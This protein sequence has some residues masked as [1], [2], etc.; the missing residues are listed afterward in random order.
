MFT[1][2]H[3]AVCPH[4]LNFCIFWVVYPNQTSFLWRIT[5]L[6][7]LRTVFHDLLHSYQVLHLPPTSLTGTAC[8]SWF[9]NAVLL[10]QHGL[11][12]NPQVTNY[13]IGNILHQLDSNQPLLFLYVSPGRRFKTDDE[14]F[15]SVKPHLNF[16]C[17]WIISAH[18]PHSSISKTCF[19]LHTTT[20]YILRLNYPL[21]ALGYFWG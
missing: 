17:L 10:T 3:W 2:F 15:G 11:D 18:V 20:G 14:D 13:F 5:S 4:S 1:L 7:H 6:D 19:R 21:V 8:T 9:T 12:F 16:V